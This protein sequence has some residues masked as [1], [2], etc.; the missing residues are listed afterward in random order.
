MSL[1]VFGVLLAL[2]IGIDC[3]LLDLPL[4]APPRLTGALLVVAMSGGFLLA[5][6]LLR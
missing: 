4:P 2:A 6:W 3:R 1:A 5:D